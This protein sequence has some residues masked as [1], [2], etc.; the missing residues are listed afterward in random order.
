MLRN[1]SN[2]HMKSETTTF[3]DLTRTYLEEVELRMRQ[4]AGHYHAN[5]DKAIDQLLSSGGKR[6]RPIAAILIGKMLNADME[7]IMVHAAAIEMLHTATLVH[8]DLIDGSLL[9]RGFPTLN[10]EWTPGATVLAGDY[11]FARA[12]RGQDGG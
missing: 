6:I 9:R 10:A 1:Y 8:D 7:R 4:S 5:L 12:A 11:I 2:G 3:F